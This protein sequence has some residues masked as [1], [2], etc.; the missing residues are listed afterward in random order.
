MGT[1]LPAGFHNSVAPGTV[2]FQAMAAFGTAQVGIFHGAA[3]LRTLPF[4]PG[5]SPEK[6]RDHNDQGADQQKPEYWREIQKPAGM[7]SVSPETRHL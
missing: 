6:Q 4:F 2:T 5:V 3:T 1:E 7:P